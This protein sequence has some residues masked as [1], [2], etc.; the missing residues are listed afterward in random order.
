[1]ARYT[2]PK[3]KLSRR[4]GIDLAGKGVKLRRLSVPPGV[5]GPK[6]KGKKQSNF[7]I[8]LREKQKVKRTYGLLEKQFSNYVQTALKSRGNTTESLLVSL[9]RRIDNVLYRSGLVPTRNMARQLVVHGHVK[10]EGKKVDRP[11]YSVKAG[12]IIS[13]SDKAIK[14]PTLIKQIDQGNETQSNWIKRQTAVIE[15]SRMPTI[16]DLSE[17]LSWNSVIEYYSR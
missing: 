4:E 7:G 10:V 1:M 9:E 17:T 12:E 16:E 14:M 3:N 8:Q 13:V 5:H 2:G 11:S 6:T 15:V